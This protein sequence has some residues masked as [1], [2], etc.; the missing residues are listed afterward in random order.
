MDELGPAAVAGWRGLE[1]AVRTVLPGLAAVA[2]ARR[3]ALAWG[4]VE[5][6]LG[7]YT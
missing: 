1:P 4:C 5:R 7:I 6:G 2:C 3:G